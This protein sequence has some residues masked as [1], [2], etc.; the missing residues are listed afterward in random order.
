MLRGLNWCALYRKLLSIL[1][2]IALWKCHFILL[3]IVMCVLDLF[4]GVSDQS[5]V[6]LTQYQLS[7]NVS[8]KCIHGCVTLT[9]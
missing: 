8:I 9:T 3:V 1:L 2:G 4:H 6:P 5:D 7:V